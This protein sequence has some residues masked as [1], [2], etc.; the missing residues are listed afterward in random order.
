MKELVMKFKQLLSLIFLSSHL[1]QADNFHNQLII[2]SVNIYNPLWEFAGQTISQ[3]EDD[4]FE[5]LVSKWHD[6][7]DILCRKLNSKIRNDIGASIHQLDFYME[8]KIFVDIYTNYYERIFGDMLEDDPEDDP[9]VL[10][11]IQLKLHYLQCNKP[12][13]IRLKDNLAI[14]SFSFGSDKDEHYLFLNSN[15]YSPEHIA[16]VYE[17]AAQKDYKF[18]LAPH[19]NYHESRVIEYC[20]LL[21]FWIAQ[22]L[23]GVLH[24]SDYFSKLL[25][26]FTNNNKSNS[27]ETYTYGADYI[28][29][30]SFL[31]GCL[32]S[33]N[34]VEAAIF[35][36]PQLDNLSQEFV[37][38]WR[39]F[40]EDIKNCYDED[41][42]HDYLIRARHERQSHLYTFADDEDDSD[43]NE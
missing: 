42:L 28:Q 16:H 32:Q 38:L 41:D 27:K 4:S 11:F 36:E 14:P 37:L 13:N 22:A 24:Q 3:K 39:E 1:I 18:Y 20:N 9:T 34:P 23:S 25:I 12:I 26:Y 35:F 10:N 19:V 2:P 15:L 17:L 31:E 40:I 43:E 33:K 29:F 8:Q 5:Q 30:R 21:H 6:T 7:L